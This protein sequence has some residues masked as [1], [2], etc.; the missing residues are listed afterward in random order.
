V[1]KKG[2]SPKLTIKPSN[3]IRTIPEALSQGHAKL[4]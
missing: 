2:N 1:A 3:F 4:F